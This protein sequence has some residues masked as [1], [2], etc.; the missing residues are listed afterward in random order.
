[1]ED[2]GF[3][4]SIGDIVKF[5]IEPTGYGHKM[6]ITSRR[7]EECP[8][9]IQRHYVV[10]PGPSIAQREPGSAMW[11]NEIELRSLKELERLREEIYVEDA[12]WEFEEYKKRSE[13]RRKPSQEN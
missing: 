11:V 4:F 8:G 13:E 7:L 12:I 2:F 5:F 10:R 1:M 6:I 3:K 9:G